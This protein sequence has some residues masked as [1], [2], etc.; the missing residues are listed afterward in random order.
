MLERL[1]LEA[2]TILQHLS[3]AEK[4]QLS[5]V[6]AVSVASP[7]NQASCFLLSTPCKINQCLHNWKPHSKQSRLILSRTPKKSAPEGQFSKGQL[8]CTLPNAGLGLPSP[9]LRH[10]FGSLLL[11]LFT[12]GPNPL[13]SQKSMRTRRILPIV[14]NSVPSSYVPVSHANGFKICPSGQSGQVRG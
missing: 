6:E 11:S 5:T 4:T 13:G 7:H 8:H 3:I 12:R 2:E 14:A 9:V 1:W 10:F